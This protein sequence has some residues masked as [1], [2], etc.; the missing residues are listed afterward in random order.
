MAKQIGRRAF[1]G[2]AAGTAVAALLA[3]CGSTAAPTPAP[4]ATAAPAGGAA[5][6]P[7]AP[8]ATSAPAAATTAP[9][10][11][12][13]TPPAAAA[14]PA[15]GAA[16]ATKPAAAA[17]PAAGKRGGTF[18]YAEAGDFNNF[19]PWNFGAVNFEMYDQVFSRLLWKDGTGKANPDLAESW[20]LAPDNLSIKLKLRDGLK[21]HD[22]KP[23]TAD[24]FVTMFGYNKD[25]A[26]AK[27]PSVTK[28]R[29][30]MTPIK[31][32]TAPDKSTVQM[33]FS[34]PV[35]YITDILD[36]WFL[37]RIDDKSD[38][39]FLKKPP[40]GTGPFKQVEWQPNQF[41]RYTRN[42]DYW[43]KDF[44]L[45][46][47]FLF[48]R[49]SQAE[50]LLPNLKS[51]AVDGILMTSLSDVAPMQADKG[52]TVD[53][54][55]NAGSIFNMNV[56]ISKPPLDK[57][58]VRQALSYSLNRVEMAKSA[59][60]GVSKPI[61][62]TF[63]SPASLAYRED[64][65]MAHPFDLQKA[66]QLLDGA[67]VKSLDLTLVV[68]PAWPQMKLFGLVWQQDLAKINVNLKIN[69]VENAKFYE[70]GGAKDLQGNDLIAW[71][72]GRTTRDP[73]IFW[74]TQGNYRGGSTNPY[75][76][77]NDDM[78]KQI[79]AAAVET[80]PD[81]RKKMYQALNELAISES[82]V[83]AVA[84][85]PRIWAYRANITGYK[86]DLNGNLFLDAV[87]KG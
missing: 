51:G 12:A 42:P 24:D 48:K 71:L 73:A 75:G 31:D 14:T 11:A 78:E 76:Y 7:A 68:T 59:F 79:A 26:L 61:T 20:Q 45:I 85:N 60:F 2:A 3:A 80:D 43:N 22:G 8:A 54:N 15:A 33:T 37:I 21:W 86:V 36:Y 77:K 10:A 56:N 65:V 64:L 16:A 41:A 18:N 82:H 27:D 70:I 87:S 34:A 66:R 17:A 63:Y 46:D 55:D 4:A 9:A 29:G 44:P 5:T 28:I 62:S 32:V 50:T 57:K 47:E 38:P 81:K 58:E 25:E 69:E 84:T 39:Q 83:I 74:S 13:T 49:L 52:Y 1:V 72:N 6:K 35:P 67:G 40:I 23:V 53:V 19:N 30:L